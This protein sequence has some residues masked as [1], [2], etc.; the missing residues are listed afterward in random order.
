MGRFAEALER[1]ARKT[2]AELASEISSLTRLKDDEINALFPTKPDKEKLLKLLDIVN[3]AT[4]ENNKILELKTN[5]EDV[6]GAVVKIVKF[7]V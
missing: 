1:A 4:D 5:I 6:A 7:L 3:A 2:D